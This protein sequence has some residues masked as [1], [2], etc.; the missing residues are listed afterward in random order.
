M[1]KGGWQRVATAMAVAG[2]A[3]GCLRYPAAAA[4]GISRGLA[5]CGQVL[6]PALFPFLVLSAFL[7]RSGI[8]A[9]IGRRLERPTRHLFGLP[10]CC[11]TGILMAFLGGYPA[12]AAAV[13][14]LRQKN[15]ITPEEGRRMMRFCVAGGP[16]F[17]VN[18]VGVGMTG[19]PQVGWMLLAAQVGSALLIGLVGAPLSARK[20]GVSRPAARAPETPATAFT[21]AVQSAG[22]TMLAMCSF[23]LLFSAVLSLFDT[24]ALPAGIGLLLSCLLEVTGGCAAAVTAGIAAPFLLGFTVCF[25]GL[26]VHCQLAAILKHSGVMG[27]GFFVFRL[28]HGLLGGLITAVL[29]SVVELP[30]SVLGGQGAPMG[31]WISGNAFIS[32]ALLMLCG[33]WMLSALPK[34]VDDCQKM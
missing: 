23:V 26:S 34:S 6:I 27:M 19:Y 12:G 3:I 21:G 15:E 24:V 4:G 8:A 2:G 1:T 33:I 25:G 29:F 11:A 16:G 9:A 10:G 18:A 22:E 31:Q 14:Q 28:V 5:L 30:L 20:A 17:V 32:A 7:I 13:A